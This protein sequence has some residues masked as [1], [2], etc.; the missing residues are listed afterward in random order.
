MITNTQKVVK[1]YNEGTFQWKV[2]SKSKS[3]VSHLVTW[4]EDRGWRCDCKGFEF[5][6]EVPKSCNHIKIIKQKYEN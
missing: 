6:A 1:D 5:S 3:G 4:S 2:P